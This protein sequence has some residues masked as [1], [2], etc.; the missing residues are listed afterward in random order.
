MLKKNDCPV[1][2]W[3]AFYIIIL[4]TVRNKRRFTITLNLLSTNIHRQKQYCYKKYY[5]VYSHFT[6]LQ[7]GVLLKP[8]NVVWMMQRKHRMRLAVT[9]TLQQ[10]PSLSRVR[11]LSNWLNPGAKKNAKFFARVEKRMARY[12]PG[13]AQFKTGTVKK[14]TIMYNFL[15]RFTNAQPYTY[16]KAVWCSG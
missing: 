10:L 9:A 6:C 14:A 4:I 7:H 1:S 3:Q 11:N 8:P 13:L 5:L 15:C 2:S 16:W 12:M